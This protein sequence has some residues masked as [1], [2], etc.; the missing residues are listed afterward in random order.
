MD[1]IPIKHSKIAKDGIPLESQSKQSPERKQRFQVPGEVRNSCFSL[2]NI[3]SSL[4]MRNQNAS[5]FYEKVINISIFLYMPHF[6][7]MNS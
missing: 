3:Y 7:L 2:A 1:H 5:S 4:N 6:I